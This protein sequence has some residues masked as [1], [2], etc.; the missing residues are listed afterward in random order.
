MEIQL[1]V[2][3]SLDPLPGYC[4][5]STLFLE[6]VTLTL[7]PVMGTT[8]PCV[9]EVRQLRPHSPGDALQGCGEVPF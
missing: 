9:D 8:F 1:R 5:H 2:D 4:L 6:R 3:M 7:G